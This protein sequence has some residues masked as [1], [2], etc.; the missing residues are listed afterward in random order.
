M[1]NILMHDRRKLILP[2]IVL[3]ATF[4][5]FG[6]RQFGNSNFDEMREHQRLLSKE[7]VEKYCGT[8]SPDA[9]KQNSY[10]N[11]TTSQLNKYYDKVLSAR[12]ENKL[13]ANLVLKDDYQAYVKSLTAYYVPWFILALLTLLGFFCCCFYCCSSPWCGKCCPC[14]KICLGWCIRESADGEPFTKRHVFYCLIP[15]LIFG[16]LGVIASIIGIVYN[17][18]LAQGLSD[19]QCA[20][21]KLLEN[22]E[23]GATINI[24][25]KSYKWLGLSNLDSQLGDLSASVASAARNASNSKIDSSSLDD[26]YNTL[27]NSIETFAN[28][29]KSFT[30]RSP[31]PDTASS[32]IRSDV[33][34]NVGPSSK[35][36]A[37][38]GMIKAEM[39]TKATVVYRIIKDVSGFSDTINTQSGSITSS[40]SS[41]RNSISNILSSTLKLEKDIDDAFSQSQSDKNSNIRLGVSGMFAWCFLFVL[42]GLIFSLVFCIVRKKWWRYTLYFV[43]VIAAWLTIISFILGGFLMTVGIAGY[44]GCDVIERMLNNKDDYNRIAARAKAPDV[45][46][47]LTVCLFGN[48]SILS[49]VA[50]SQK[51]T[52]VDTATSQLKLLRDVQANI[53]NYRTSIVIPRIKNEFTSITQGLLPA[54]TPGKSTED[55]ASILNTFN[56]LTDYSTAN[57]RQTTCKVSRDNWAFNSANCSAG[58]PPGQSLGLPGDPSCFGF[59]NIP[60]AD[61]SSRYSKG[62]FSSCSG[63]TTST[64]LL[65]YVNSLYNYHES[66]QPAFNTL[67]KAMD[68]INDN[69]IKFMD[70][71]QGLF[72][73]VFSFSDKIQGL[74]DKATN[75]ETGLFPQMNC[76]F[77][78]AGIKAFK[79]AFCDEAFD[80]LFPIGACLVAVSFVMML[81][82]LFMFCAGLRL[83][84]TELEDK[85][86]RYKEAATKS[87]GY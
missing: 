52:E 10:V 22:F 51:L 42:L 60:R 33:I 26:P 59:N 81:F 49:T 17:S 24:D 41:V 37:Y 12:G 65:R 57:S 13:Y 56:Q 80:S 73:P 7:L 71:A 27:L 68:P 43:W 30:L 5:V 54:V 48:G 38:A 72:T 21:F 64:N 18:N 87:P 9:L 69:N 66:I 70:K 29:G 55:P 4:L 50:G 15:A 31:N 8:I 84:Y 63:Q 46:D 82:T 86:D 76:L 36:T 16:A 44:E 62:S 39:D 78:T 28:S 47:R 40:I 2:C 83:S 23:N 34:D 58:Y 1:G 25:G 11:K 19:S 67:S 32:T 35:S 85:G 45:T 61:T 77:V 20:V 3:V 75:P 14:C 53:S 74:L 79:T 6:L